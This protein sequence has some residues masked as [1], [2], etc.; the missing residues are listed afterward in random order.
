MM[1]MS[2]EQQAQMSAL[3]QRTFR[4]EGT[5]ASFEPVQ[6]KLTVGES[7]DKYEQEADAVARTVVEKINAP[8]TESSVQRQSEVGGLSQLNI[9]VMRHSKSGVGEGA[10]VTQDVEQGIQQAKGGGQTLDESLREP[11][12]QAFGADFSGVKLHADSN[13]DML[14]RSISA[15]AFTTGQDIFFKQGEYNPGS[16]GGQE[17]LAHE[18]TH[19]VQQTGGIQLQRK[20]GEDLLPTGTDIHT[21]GIVSWEEGVNLRNKPHPGNQ[22]TV[23]RRL[24]FNQKLFVDKQL[25]DGWYFVTL[26]TGEYGYVVTSAI[27]TNLPEP[28]AKLH[29]ISAGESAI[30]IAEQYYKADAQSWGQDLRFY[31]NVLEFVNRGDGP[32]GIYKANPD[33]SWEN[34]K[35]RD[36]YFI[37]ITSVDFAKTLKG[38]VKSGS[39]TYD[40]WTTVK[41]TAIAIGEFIVGGGAFIAGLLHGALESVWDILVGLK[42]LAVMVWDVLKSL[43][44]G[45]ILSDAKNL[46]DQISSLDVSQIVESWISDFKKKWNDESLLKR[47]HFRGWVIGYAIAEIAILIFSGGTINGAKWVG[48]MAKIAKIIEKLPG[49]KRLTSLIKESKSLQK[50][51]TA[52]NKKVTHAT[53]TGA[54]TAKKLYKVSSQMREKILWGK[55]DGN[56]LIG[57]HFRGLVG[58]PDYAAEIVG[59]STM[60]PGCLRVKFIKKL[61]DGSL[62]KIKSPASTLFPK[63]WSKSDIIKAIEDVA[64]NPQ[65]SWS[66]IQDRATVMRGN[67]KGVHI[68]VIVDNTGKIS[69]G[70]PL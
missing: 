28:G 16:R 70:Y 8:T 33:D 9:T 10:S 5:Q 61:P 23:L 63:G 22:S 51:K 55:L 39:I 20:E 50:I 6:A 49:V 4:G 52:L 45:E 14:N 65:T 69:A 66:R 59:V 3:I 53:A 36:G 24:P 48:K 31:V 58:H 19:V 54:T 40:A 29:K 26:T 1:Q 2:V 30:G 13:A 62:S 41:N 67:V 21:L 25:P 60:N 15:R 43:F 7:G 17:L 47:W 32:R 57:G 37:W 27:K 34:T 46:W 42:D 35:T 56:R 11:M 68:E 44:S 64:N 18:L 38:Q 12:E